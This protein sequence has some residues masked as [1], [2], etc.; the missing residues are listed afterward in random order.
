MNNNILSILFDWQNLSFQDL[1]NLC[2]DIHMKNIRWLAMNHPDNRTR[3][4]L[5]RL[6]NVEVGQKTVINMG[7]HIYDPS[8]PL[9]KIGNYCA[10]GAYVSLIVDSNPNM[11]ELAEIPFVKD[12]YIKSGEII[13]EDHAWIGANAIIFPGIII[14]HHAIV[15][16]AS[17]VTKNV[18]PYVVVKGQPA[19]P[20]R[21]LKLEIQ[22]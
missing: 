4:N 11:S 10:I 17:I 8:K 13:I 22:K 19:K 18:P 9:V 1:K 15:G 2:Q 21:D 3:E 7:L 6:S 5:F 20:V 16:A 12:H 14:G